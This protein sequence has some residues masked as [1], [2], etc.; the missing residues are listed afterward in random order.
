MTETIAHGP[1]Q[2]I[3]P[4][5]IVPTSIVPWACVAGAFGVWL[6]AVAA[7][8]VLP[9]DHAAGQRVAVPTGVLVLHHDPRSQHSVAVREVR[10]L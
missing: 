4:R 8:T 9:Q 1:A 7:M 5:H 10:P 6:A 3:L 2:H